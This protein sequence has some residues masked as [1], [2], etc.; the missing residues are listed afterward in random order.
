MLLFAV[1]STA[2]ARCLAEMLPLNEGL[3][4]LDVC[5]NSHLLNDTYSSFVFKAASLNAR[6][7]TLRGEAA[8]FGPTTTQVRNAQPCALDDGHGGCRPSSPRRASPAR[9]LY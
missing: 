2:G 4:S 7:H 9:L 3:Q 8:G 5:H 1:L 6:L